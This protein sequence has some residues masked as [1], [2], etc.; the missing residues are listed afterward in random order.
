[1]SHVCLLV[2]LQ[3]TWDGKCEEIEHCFKG[4]AS[5]KILHRVRIRNQL[6]CGAILLHFI[7]IDNS[8]FEWKSW[9]VCLQLQNYRDRWNYSCLS[10]QGLHLSSAGHQCQRHSPAQTHTHIYQPQISANRKNRQL[11]IEK[12]Q[13]ILT[14]RHLFGVSF[15][16][17][18]QLFDSMLKLHKCETEMTVFILF[19]CTFL[20][21]LHILWAPH[22]AVNVFL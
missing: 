9:V 16:F 2:C 15:S 14:G 3:G 17:Y 8:D 21:F 4:N 6:R 20:R 22:I 5:I 7:K 10:S 11:S 18:M 19:K 12:I 1:M 13:I